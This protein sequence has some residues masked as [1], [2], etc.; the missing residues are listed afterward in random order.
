MP[1]VNQPFVVSSQGQ[2]GEPAIGVTVINPK[3][4]MEIELWA[5][6]DTGAHTCVFAPY[7][8]DSIGI[9]YKSVE[10]I[11]QDTAGANLVDAYP[12]SV[13]IQINHY[14]PSPRTEAPRQFRAENIE[15]NFCEDITRSLLGVRGFL[16]RFKVTIDY[17]EKVFSLHYPDMLR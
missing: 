9:D 8:A 17:T 12:H 5:V 14:P 6:I 13:T 15:V 7:V 11:K 3:N 16:E 2:I 4:D 1:I 10:P